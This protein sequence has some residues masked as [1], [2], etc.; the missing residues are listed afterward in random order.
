MRSWQKGYHGLLP[1]PFLDGLH[2]SQRV[3]RRKLIIQQAAWPC[4]GTLVAED[5]RDVVGFTDLC[6]TRDDDRDAVEVGEI[7]SFYVLPA[8]WRRGVGR[9]LMT[10]A[11]LALRAA[12][13]SSATLWVL[14]G[15]VR[16][17]RFYERM[18]WQPDGAVKNAVTGG[19]AVR[20]LRYRCEFS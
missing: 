16:A 1:Q 9:E 2:P 11:M 18:G 4:R 20:E 6:P 5:A 19:I 14:E 15:N 10:A 12:N 17:I 8:A 13:F 7:G 3:P